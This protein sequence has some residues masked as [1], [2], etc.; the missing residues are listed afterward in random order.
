MAE[1][2]DIMP[3]HMGPAERAL[4]QGVIDQFGFP[5]LIRD[6]WSGEAAPDDFLP[7]IAW[8]LS[9]DDWSDAWTADA[10]RLAVSEALDRHRRKGTVASVRQQLARLG[11]PDAV[12]IEDRDLPRL[13]RG[14]VL[15][16][17]WCLGPTDSSWSDYWVE[18]A[19]PLYRSDAESM[20]A[21][22]GETAP[23]RCRLRTIRA[24]VPGRFRLGD[25]LWQLGDAVTIG[26]T[27]I[28]GDQDG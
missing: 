23:V 5:I 13:G 18:V 12:V 8:A 25:G 6:T 15:G 19:I 28:F 9:V 27:Y 14:W 21:R 2:D 4:M 17:G 20:A 24:V 11:Y 7:F 22:L 26:S 10:K 3:A 16:L 1:I